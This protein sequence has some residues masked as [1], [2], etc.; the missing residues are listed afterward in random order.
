M[1]KNE[2][3]IG[4]YYPPL[5]KIYKVMRLATFLLILSIAQ[6]QAINTY[7]QQT[8]L[9]LNF[10]NT[11]LVEVLDK[12]EE[13]SEFY[14]LYNEKLLDTD[15]KVT[16]N[17]DQ[18]LI[19]SIL[20]DLFA[21]TEI[22][23]T[24]VD[25]KIILAPEYIFETS[26]YQQIKISGKV[27]DRETGEA[28]AGVNIQVKGTSVG[29]I[30]DLNGQYS[31]PATV[32]PNAVLV[33]SF[34]GYQTLEVPVEG[35]QEVNIQLAGELQGLEE[36]VVIGYGVQRKSD[37]TGA[38]SSIRST[39]MVNRS[40]TS[41]V[42]ALAGKTSGVS[43]ISTGG[44]PGQAG[45]MLIRGY[46]SNKSSYPL[47]VVDGLRVNNINDLDPNTIESIEVLKDAASAAIY[48]AE[49][50]NGVIMVTTKKGSSGTSKISYEFQYT[51][52]SMVRT[53]K[54][55]NAA[56]YVDWLILNG[57]YTQNDI[58]ATIS[59]GLWDGNSS[60]DWMEEM[61]EQ[62]ISP[63]HIL[64]FQGGNN[65]GS[66]YISL[67]KTN[68]DG[69]VVNNFDTFKRINATL[70]GSYKFRPWLEIGNNTNFMTSSTNSVTG[71]SG[72]NESFFGYIYYFDPTVSV[73][74]S[75]D[76]L[77]TYMQNHLNMGRN[78]LK[79][80]NGDYY[81]VSQLISTNP[82]NPWVKLNSTKKENNS[83][84][85][86][87]TAYANLTPFKGFTYTTRIGYNLNNNNAWNLNRFYYGS[88]SDYTN[89]ASVNRSLTS[90]SY[91]QW[92]NFA[93]YNFTL[94]DQHNF[95]TMLGM[96]YSEN[97]VHYL[98]GSESKIRE[99]VEENPLFWDLAYKASDSNDDVTATHN[100][101]HKLS[102]YGRLNYSFKDLY[103]LQFTMR[104]DAADLSVLSE[105]NRWG[106]FP[107]VSAG[108]QISNQSWFPE[109]PHFDYMK[110][111]AS[112]GQNGSTSSLS[113]Y[114]YATT[115]ST[116][117]LGYSF[118]G[119]T[120]TVSSTTSGLSNE[121][122][123]WETSEQL[124]FGTDV[125][126]FKSRLTFS[127]D[128]YKKTTID[129]ILSTGITVS[130]SAGAS[131]PV[132]NGGS[133]LNRGWE[134]EAGWKDKMND[135]SYGINANF[136]SLHNEVISIHNTVTR[137]TA[138][139]LQSY[140]DLTAFEVGHPVWYIWTYKCE[141][142]DPATGNAIITD[143]DGN[144]IINVSDKVESGSGLPDFQYGLT[145]NASYKNFNLTLFGQGIGGNQVF[146]A[147]APYQQNTLKYFYDKTWTP[148]T[149]TTATM[150]PMNS[151]NYQYYIVSDAFVFDAGYFKIKQIQLG[152][153]LP[154]R[155]ISKVALK[156]VRLYASLEDWFNFTPY[157]VGM[158]PSVSANNSTGMGIDYG[159]YPNFK[160]TVFGI[161]V[162]F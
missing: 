18:Q 37:V 5:K 20:D 7:A 93:N 19:T 15:R 143:V 2:P 25:R 36:V 103:T 148:T 113:N 24:V 3:F 14:F 111:R 122:L 76:D 159:S 70:N 33:F 158:D 127:A 77:P 123:K 98:Y 80:D 156:E 136:S 96:S 35:R 129:L 41:I 151:G 69:I 52:N 133:V 13:G 100:W 61:T 160:K 79:D 11:E 8:R 86:S 102:Y 140:G 85:V 56:E 50:G 101:Q 125:R 68:Q 126:F 46:S 104:A 91:W 71:G 27:T 31:L 130:A 34:I 118:D 138:N 137:Y 154:T 26:H 92:E 83:I 108:W 9:S 1:K 114:S 10:T 72:L 147:T 88:P 144:G 28:M 157:K 78:L 29:A 75:P 42:D 107:A 161:N 110:I 57:K 135:F 65:N 38:I 12:I 4:S 59:A 106:F 162:A 109:I 39:D 17:A 105:K 63:R 43:I 116:T 97:N 128:W 21:N 149:S 112:W 150:S 40:N 132:M 49:A 119:S 51:I 139:S 84:M 45:T 90:T 30:S 53:P 81:G 155:I 152:Y 55:L 22:K 73:T 87:G 64:S 32:E 58:D 47:Y 6:L 54:A 23:Y 60:T 44:A 120:Y 146:R 95:I 153:N 134:F 115:I 141:G 124:D 121:D 48:G 142:I 131:A 62:G 67:A 82:C 145:L 99:D 94:A 89:D 117:A 16:L 66:Y 74:Y